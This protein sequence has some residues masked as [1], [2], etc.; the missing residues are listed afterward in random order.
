MEDQIVEPIGGE[1]GGTVGT[2][3]P[4][5]EVIAQREY[6]VSLGEDSGTAEENWE[7]ARRE[8]MAQPR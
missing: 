8:L 6:E 3:E 4:T 5:E 7:R 2:A 1:E